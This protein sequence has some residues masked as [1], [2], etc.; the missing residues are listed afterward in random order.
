MP[1]ATTRSKASDALWVLV[2]QDGPIAKRLRGK[3]DRA[4][5]RRACI[6]E[7]KPQSSIF[8]IEKLTKGRVKAS[9][10][11][12]PALGPPPDV[13]VYNRTRPQRRSA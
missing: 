7:R 11:E 5:L 8:L 9:W 13:W 10:W 4:R 3:I 12:V 1:K 2:D 6:G